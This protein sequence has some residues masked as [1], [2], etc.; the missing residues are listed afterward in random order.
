MPFWL[1]VFAAVQPTP[2][3]QAGC[4]ARP[5]EPPQLDDWQCRPLPHCVLLPTHVGP[6]PPLWSQQPSRQALPSQQGEPG[7]PHSTQTLATQAT[8]CAP[9]PS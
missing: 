2:L 5:H 9:A 3:L 8:G 1:N 7:S 4:P 6:L